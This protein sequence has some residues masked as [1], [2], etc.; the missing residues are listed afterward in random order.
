MDGRQELRRT[1]GA[2]PK[3]PHEGHLWRW[4]CLD[5]DRMEVHMLAAT[6]HSTFANAAV[7]G[8]KVKGARDLSYYFYHTHVNLQ[9]SQN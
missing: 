8:N 7:V 1:V 5:L 2:A 4:K 6:L 3:G 9:L